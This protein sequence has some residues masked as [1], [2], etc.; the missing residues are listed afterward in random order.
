MASKLC[1]LSSSYAINLSLAF[2]YRWNTAK[3]LSILFYCK[4]H[5]EIWRPPSLSE[6]TL[7]IFSTGVTH[8][9]LEASISSLR[10]GVTAP[11]SRRYNG[12]LVL[13][14]SL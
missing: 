14:T 8:L 6:L 13:K 7:M 2:Y 10:N 12:K 1:H 3:E 4:Y 9:G 11:L 5:E